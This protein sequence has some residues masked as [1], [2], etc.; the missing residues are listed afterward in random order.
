MTT[1]EKQPL[2]EVLLIELSAALADAVDTM[3]ASRGASDEMRQTLAEISEAVCKPTTESPALASA[4]KALADAL[5]EPQAPR[6][7]PV[8]HQIEVNPTPVEVCNEIVCAPVVQITPA[9]RRD[10]EVTHRYDTRGRL[11][12]STIT[13]TRTHKD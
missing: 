8:T 12:S 4:L 2:N 7:G 3:K 11:E 5:R 6:G 1:G 10:Y 13:C 9:L